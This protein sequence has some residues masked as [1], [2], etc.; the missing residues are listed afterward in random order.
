MLFDTTI[1]E[2]IRFGKENATR[3]EIEEA[4]QQANAHYFIMKLPNVCID[5]LSCLHI[6][7]I[8]FYIEI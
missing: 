2:N 7:F 5:Y 3:V 8:C 4:A 1:Y 6:C